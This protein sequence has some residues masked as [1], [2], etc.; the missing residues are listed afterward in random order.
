[1]ANQR[2]SRLIAQGEAEHGGHT[3]YFLTKENE[4]L[5]RAD[6]RRYVCPSC[7]Q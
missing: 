2:I 4:G 3:Y 5:F 6:P 7:P 1:V